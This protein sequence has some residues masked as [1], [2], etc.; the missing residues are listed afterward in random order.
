MITNLYARTHP[1]DVAGMVFVDGASEF[2]RATFTR[3]QGTE[4]LRRVRALLPT[5]TETPRY[6]ASTDEIRAA[7]PVRVPAAVR[8]AS[9]PWSVLAG[10]GLPSTWPA[11]QSAQDRLADLW[12]ATHITRTRSG[13][14]IAIERPQ[15]V[16]SAIRRVLRQARARSP[17]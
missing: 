8:T 15:I 6:Q 11:W 12:H 13:H 5:G 7:G 2:L 1:R 14:V 10:T 3:A 9:Q 16:V 17:R 4:Y